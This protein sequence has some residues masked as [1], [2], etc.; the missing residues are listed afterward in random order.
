VNTLKGDG[1]NITI[2]IYSDLICP[3]CYIGKRRI[4]KAIDSVRLAGEQAISVH[5]HPFQ[6]NPNMPKEGIL[7]RDYRTAK[8][9][10]WERS[11]DLDFQVEKVGLVEGIAFQFARIERTPNTVDS[12][13]IVALAAEQGLQ[14]AVVEAM[15]DAYFIQTRDLTIRENLVAVGVSAGLDRSRIQS[16]LEGDEGLLEIEQAVQDAR[17]YQIEGVPF[18][19]FDRRIAISGAQSISV[20]VNTLNEVLQHDGM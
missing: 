9:G 5:W 20:F 16:I 11:L 8:F 3:W 7:R 6:L 13:R 15:F 4:E 2:D 10:S 17:H 18:F 12:H 1:M 14:N 19:I